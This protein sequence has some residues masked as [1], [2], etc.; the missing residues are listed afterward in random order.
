MGRVC[1]VVTDGHH[2]Y[3]AAIIA[4]VACLPVE[5]TFP[6]EVRDVTRWVMAAE[7]PQRAWPGTG[8]W[9]A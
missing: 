7:K 6:E 8:T 1:P 4:G 2:L 5:I 3:V 9:P